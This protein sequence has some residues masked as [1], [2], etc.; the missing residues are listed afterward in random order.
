MPDPPGKVAEG[1]SK[2][3]HSLFDGVERLNCCPLPNEFFRIFDEPRSGWAGKAGGGGWPVSGG[4]GESWARVLTERAARPPRSEKIQHGIATK[5]G[6]PRGRS[7]AA[8]CATAFADDV[9]S[10]CARSPRFCLSPLYPRWRRMMAVRD[11]GTLLVWSVQGHAVVI[12]D[13]R[14]G[15]GDARLARTRRAASSPARWLNAA[16]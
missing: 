15:R 13:V 16:A 3:I 10:S 2:A 1:F 12:D 9:R 5:G 8:S 7:V 6:G 14:A 11:I 4:F